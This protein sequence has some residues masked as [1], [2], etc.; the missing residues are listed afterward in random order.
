[1]QAWESECRRYSVILADL[2]KARLTAL[3]LLTALMGFYLGVEGRLELGLLVHTLIGIGLVAGG[4][5]ACNQLIECEHDA[6]M[7]R[8]A[9][10]PLPRKLIKPEFAMVFGMGASILGI[11]WLWAGVNGL[12]AGLALFSWLSYV[13][14][15]TPLKR[16]TWWNTLVGAVPGAMPPL[17]GWA[18]ATGELSLQGAVL[19]GILFF[20]Q[21]PHFLSIGWMYRD[22]YAGAGFRMLPVED[23]TGRR[24]GR[25]SVMYAGILLGISLLPTLLGVS[26]WIYF[27]GALMLGVAFLISAMQFAR[28]LGRLEARRLFLGSI[29]YLPLLLFL[30]VSNKV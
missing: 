3:V 24:T 14:V 18:A 21:M 5:A 8:T 22:E 25:Q 17:M 30:M 13:C 15:Y 10:R 6:R 7:P 16:V 26:G 12:T 23:K 2:V 9:G 29:T 27:A 11:V 28:R 1:M 20:W 19:F 4:A